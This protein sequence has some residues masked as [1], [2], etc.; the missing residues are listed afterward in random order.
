MKKPLAGK[1]AL[2]TGAAGP[3]VWAAC[4]VLSEDGCHVITA[5]INAEGLE[6]EKVPS[7]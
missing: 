1:T 6:G 2:V 5:D 3:I 7:S 4:Q